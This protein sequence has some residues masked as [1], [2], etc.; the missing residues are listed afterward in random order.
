[1]V[2]VLADNPS[3]LAYTRLPYTVQ[4]GILYRTA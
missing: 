4:K 3:H 1:M 2:P